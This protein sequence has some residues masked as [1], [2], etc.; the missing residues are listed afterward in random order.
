MTGPACKIARFDHSVLTCKDI[1]ATV[2]WY[3]EH[4]GFEHHVEDGKH[5]LFFGTEGQ[6]LNLHQHGAEFLP[7]AANVMPGSADLC[8]TTLD[9]IQEVKA[10]LEAA[11]VGILHNEDDKQIV[12]RTS[13]AGQ[14][15]SIYMRVG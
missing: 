2:K 13:A 8:F 15:T 14:L 10:R 7:K 1:Q 12:Q 4:L 9:D 5:A 11:G 3:T 6:K